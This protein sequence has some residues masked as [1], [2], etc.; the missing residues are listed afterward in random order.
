[1]SA[2]GLVL[3][4]IVTSQ[5]PTSIDPVSHPFFSRSC[6]STQQEMLGCTPLQLDF[7]FAPQLLLHHLS[8]G[9]CTR[10]LCMFLCM[11]THALLHIQILL[12]VPITVHIS[13]L[14]NHQMG[15]FFLNQRTR[16][17]KSTGKSC[18]I[19][20]QTIMIIKYTNSSCMSFLFV[21]VVYFGLC[22]SVCEIA[23]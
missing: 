6:S 12:G 4:Q 7:S 9:C 20:I 23:Q 5:R 21:F 11:P 2:L 1:M 8:S 17:T 10:N 14:I 15:F 22:L 16:L 3:F 13:H 18:I 19:V